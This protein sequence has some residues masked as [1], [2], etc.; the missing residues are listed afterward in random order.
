MMTDQDHTAADTSGGADLT[1]SDP[2][3]PRTFWL[4]ALTRVGRA[5]GTLGKSMRQALKALLGNSLRRRALMA[6]LGTA[7]LL[8]LA[9][10]LAVWAP[11]TPPAAAAAAAPCP[12]H[13]DVGKPGKAL[14][15][16]I[17]LTPAS[18]SAQR[19]INFGTGRTMQIVRDLVLTADRP[20]PDS[21]NWQQLNFDALIS[22]DSDTLESTD[23]P[24]PTFSEPRISEDRLSITF[25]M[26]LNPGSIPPGK[27]VGTVTLSG[28]P[29]L[30]AASV[31]VTVNAK[32]A[33]PFWIG[34]VAS[35]L[36]A[37][38]LLMLKDAAAF[39]DKQELPTGWGVSFLHP[40]SDPVWWAVTLGALGAAFGSLYAVYAGNPVW[41]SGGF[42]DVA[43]LIGAAFAAI[44]G[45][46]IISA[47]TPS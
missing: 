13:L 37:F 31:S 45:Q 42:S 12:V 2:R 19:L 41:G 8:A 39:R 26:C 40:L 4:A 3:P 27:Y 5:A 34:A 9:V 11:W 20:L 28:P 29:G 22:R 7:V 35:L 46:T 17:A 32:T 21:V 43:G 6:L 14:P 15:S 38:A 1:T 33:T 24:D 30:G 23:F 44:G 18:S 36:L 10:Y 25:N 47:L 16:P